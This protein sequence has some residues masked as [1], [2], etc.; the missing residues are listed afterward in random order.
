[1]HYLKRNE[2]FFETAL[3]LLGREKT[4]DGGVDSAAFPSSPALSS[5]SMLDSLGSSGHDIAIA[6]LPPWT[7]AGNVEMVDAFWGGARMYGS[8]LVRDD[9][10]VSEGRAAEARREVVHNV[11]N[12]A[13]GG[14]FGRTR[15][16]P[17]LG[18]RLEDGVEASI[19][20]EGN[21][22][23]REGGLLVQPGAM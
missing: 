2:W 19:G 18:L 11:P 10:F 3:A 4:W 23:P 9:G 14:R 12:T 17:M 13:L 8:P 1:M 21:D 5:S 20:G 6:R 16:T 7:G 22:G 15:T